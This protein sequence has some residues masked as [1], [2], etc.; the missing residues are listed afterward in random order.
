MLAILYLLSLVSISPKLLFTPLPPPIFSE[1]KIGDFRGLCVASL[2]LYCKRND[3]ND[4]EMFHERHIVVPRV[5]ENTYMYA[6]KHTVL[7]PTFV[8]TIEYTCM[9]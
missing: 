7:L 5:K 4:V 9:L 1:L 3:S 2:I 6:L 8:C